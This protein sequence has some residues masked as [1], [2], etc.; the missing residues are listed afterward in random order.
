[1]KKSI[2]AVA[3]FFLTVTSSFPCCQKKKSNLLQ[4]INIVFFRLDSPVRWRIENTSKV[5]VGQYYGKINV[6]FRY[7]QLIALFVRIQFAQRKN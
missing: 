3:A 6:K 4:I 2:Y 5:I 7:L 1:M